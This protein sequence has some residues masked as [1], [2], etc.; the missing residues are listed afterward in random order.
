LGKNG[1]GFL[2]EFFNFKINTEI[3]DSLVIFNEN[4]YTN[5]DIIDMR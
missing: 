1:T 5:A 2:V 3:P 4:D